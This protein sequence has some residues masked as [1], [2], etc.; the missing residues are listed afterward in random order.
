MKENHGRG[1]FLFRLGSNFE[2]YLRTGGAGERRLS[3]VVKSIL[4]VDNTFRGWGKILQLLGWPW[5]RRQVLSTHTL[6]S[7]VVAFSVLNCFG[8][9]RRPL[10]PLHMYRI[11]RLL[12]FSL[13]LSSE[14][15]FR[16]EIPPS[17]RCWAAGAA[18]GAAAAPARAMVPGGAART[19]RTT[20]P[21]PSGA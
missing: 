17:R 1:A 2:R 21:F 3:Y 9:K 11:P 13:L 18:A 10:L 19:T 20:T 7:L 12:A 15:T 8:G 14:R 16:P 6:S 4:V 5:S